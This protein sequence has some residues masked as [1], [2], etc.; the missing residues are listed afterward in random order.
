MEALSRLRAAGLLSALDEHFARAMGRIGGEA[1]LE[2]LLAAALASA[3]VRQG[4]V[5]FP[6]SGFCPERDA[7]DEAGRPVDGV[8]WPAAAA[9]LEALRSSSLVSDGSRPA[10]LVLDGAGRLYLRNYWEHE[11]QLAERLAARAAQGMAWEASNRGRLRE[12]LARWFPGREAS[13]VDW[14]RVAAA[15]AALRSLCVISGGPGTGKTFSVVKIL[16]LLIEEALDAG[17]AAPRV[18]LVAPTGKAAARLGESLRRAEQELSLP[19]AL[20]QALRIEPATIHRC[21]GASG[22]AEVRFRHSEQNPLRADIVVV[23]EA[24]M[25]DLALM[26]RLV[27]ATPPAAKLVLV[28]DKDQLASVEAGAVL[29]DLCRTGAPREFSR[30]AAAALAELAGQKISVSPQAPADTGIWDCIV[31]LQHSYRYGAGSGIG[32]LA[33]AIRAGDAEEVLAILEDR[34]LADVRWIE[35]APL[36]PVHPVVRSVILAG[37]APYLREREAQARLEAFGRFR[38]LCAHRRGPHGSEALNARIAAWLGAA[39]LVEPERPYYDGRPI[40]IT[41]N[42]YNLDL[43]NGDVGIACRMGAETRV[44]FPAPGGK[45]RSVSPSR[46]PPH[47]SA[48]ATTV[49]KSQGS[50]F[51]EVVLLLPEQPSPVTTRELLYT[52]VTRVRR[53]VT[54]QGSREVIAECVRRRTE[55]SSGLRDRLWAGAG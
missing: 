17:R 29:G 54:L 39:G 35:P 5:C 14:Q 21:L 11:Q 31:E 42:D 13:G 43:F 36:A 2:V 10:P 50:E 44:V 23:D 48:Y 37:F 38:V 45:L 47:E 16:A 27:G 40:L 6:V 25:V 24:S 18:S 22:P 20:R 52:A 15:V 49:H 46:L 19:G 12:R 32:R 33:R 30:E 28:G 4:H 55:R 7:L 41:A 26:N 9:W 53:K 8:E 34:E 1:R 51:D 3:R